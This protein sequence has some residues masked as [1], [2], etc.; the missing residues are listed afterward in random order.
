MSGRVPPAQPDHLVLA[1]TTLADGIDYVSSLTGAVPQPG[2]KHATMGTHNALLRL[3]ERFYLEVIAIDPQAQKPQRARWFGL[4]GIALQAELT[5][6]PRLIH[7]VART[8][9]IDAALNA[10][11]V[12]LGS[13]HAL[14]RG[15]YRW[16]M[17]IRDDGA[18]PGKGLIP[19]LIQWQLDQ[20]PLGQHPL[21]QHALDAHPA[22]RL[23]VS[24]VSLVELAGSHP[25]PT[26]I[27]RALTQ[28]G[29][30]DRMHVTFD[31]EAR[32]VAMLRTPRGMVTLTS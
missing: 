29:L 25:E 1:A 21:D 7:W 2:G 11:G 5:L 28:L 9:D 18:L 32:L 19:T 17:T 6:Q 12:A 16:R 8:T 23:P 26:V 20:Q 13:V 22:D 10:S 14:T 3:G 27:R 24:P 30:K 4:D 31:R 15:D